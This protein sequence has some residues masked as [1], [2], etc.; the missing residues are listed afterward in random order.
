MTGNIH[1]SRKHYRD[2]IMMI[3]SL[4]LLSNKHVIHFIQQMNNSPFLTIKKSDTLSV[5]FSSL[6]LLL[7]LCRTDKLTEAFTPDNR[8]IVLVDIDSLRQFE[9]KTV[10]GFHIANLH[11]R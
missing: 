3:N 11:H 10:K 2:C 5:A 9:S 4:K 6:V 8:G 1:L 7:V